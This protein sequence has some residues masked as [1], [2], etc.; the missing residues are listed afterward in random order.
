MN[1]FNDP[2][3]FGTEIVFGCLGKLY[4]HFPEATE[5]NLELQLISQ[6]GE[7]CNKA[8]TPRYIPYIYSREVPTN[9]QAF[10]SS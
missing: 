4:F 3:Y 1:Y 7:F 9:G 8:L 5:I 2:K 10:A 6:G